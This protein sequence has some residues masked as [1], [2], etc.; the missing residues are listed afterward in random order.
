V[1]NKNNNDIIDI[2]KLKEKKQQHVNKTV[3]EL[4]HEFFYL[5]QRNTNIREKVRAKHFFCKGANLE[6]VQLEHEPYLSHFQYWFA[7]DYVNIQGKTMYQQYLHTELKDRH[8]RVGALLLAYI[9]EPIIISEISGKTC[10][11]ENIFTEKIETLQLVKGSLNANVGDLI[12]CRTVFIGYEKQLLGPYSVINKNKVIE[13]RNK[14]L[15]TFKFEKTERQIM[16]WQSYMK[17][18]GFKFLFMVNK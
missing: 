7:F 15:A 16:S 2:V 5:L 18:S 1:L 4:L 8:Y 12:L 11:G 9:I 17:R 13:V 14:M 3:D 6:L 10:K